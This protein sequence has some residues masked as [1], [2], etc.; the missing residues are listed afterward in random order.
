MF[1]TIGA[2]RAIDER[3]LAKSPH[4]VRPKDRQLLAE[5]LGRDPLT[6]APLAA[7][8]GPTPGYGQA[9]GQGP[10]PVYGQMPSYNQA[11]QPMPP[12]QPTAPV[13]TQPSAY[14]GYGSG[15]YGPT[16]S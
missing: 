9:P 15:S 11:Q 16:A 7:G 5:R 14:Q 6:G 10:A 13:Q 3:I 2:A 1:F 8:Y 12:T 4:L